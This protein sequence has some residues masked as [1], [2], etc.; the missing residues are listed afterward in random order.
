MLIAARIVQGMGAA[1]CVTNNTALLTDTFPAADLGRALGWNV[2]IAA[3]AQVAGPVVGGA[4]TA[5]FGWRGLFL[6]CAPI[7]LLALVMSLLFIPRPDRTRRRRERFDLAG[8]ALSTLA[9][10]VTVLALTTTAEA[11]P[12][13]VRVCG[14]AAV[15]LLVAFVV[16]QRRR[17]H[18][19][20]DI[21]LFRLPTIAVALTAV[22]ANAVAT[23]AVVVLVSLYGQAGGLTP[24]RAGVMV[25]LGT[26]LA[27]A[28]TAALTTRYSP[29]ILTAT[30]MAASLIG[31][32]GLAA[33]MTDDANS[34]WAVTPFL[35]VIGAGNG[36]F[37]TPSTNAL[38][39]AA[40]AARRGIANGLRSTSQNLGTLVSSAL[41][42]ALGTAGLSE[43]ARR[44]AIDGTLGAIGQVDLAHFV[45]NLRTATAVFATVAAL[46]IALCWFLPG[47]RPN[48]DP[49][50][51]ARSPTIPWTECPGSA[52]TL[53]GDS[54]DRAAT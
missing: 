43:S 7:G 46:G 53:F 24:V 26:V 25:A 44:A 22:I 3:T 27:A 31:L 34:L 50:G 38:M 17:E 4:A 48:L 30:G 49:V 11:D 33:T 14:V 5:L 6:V 1:A 54:E 41:A 40:P 23:N 39:L 13:L 21:G 2:T 42:L 29:R 8:A 18:P 45:A 10:T 32:I 47:E 20:I 12:R 52:R 28:L 51:T 19:L 35:F 36:L 16:V 37:M 15:V 9:L